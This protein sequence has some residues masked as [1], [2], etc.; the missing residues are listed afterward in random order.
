MYVRRIAE[1]AKRNLVLGCPSELF[2]WRSR[3]QSEVD[4]VIKTGE[5]MQAFEI[6]WQPKRVVSRDFSSR[7]GIEAQLISSRD[8]PTSALWTTWR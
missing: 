5:Q 4:L 1:A 3:A 6:K 2:F 8:F 7:Y